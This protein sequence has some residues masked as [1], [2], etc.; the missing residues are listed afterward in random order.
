MEHTAPVPPALM[1]SGAP[2][3]LDTRMA[4]LSDMAVN[5]RELG[6]IATADGRRIRRGIIYRSGDLSDLT[7]ACTNRMA[8]LGIVARIDFRRVIQRPRKPTDMSAYRH[9]E[10]RQTEV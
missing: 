10:Q 9:W 4:Q 7:E 6:G 1:V 5:L 3:P 2:P 8:E